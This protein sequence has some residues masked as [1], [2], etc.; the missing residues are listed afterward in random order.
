MIFE[1]FNPAIFK[2]H[3]PPELTSSSKVMRLFS[4]NTFFNVNIKQKNK[5]NK[6][7]KMLIKLY[8]FITIFLL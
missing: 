7:D 5:T 3:D 8:F 2:T 6:K 1:I 4:L